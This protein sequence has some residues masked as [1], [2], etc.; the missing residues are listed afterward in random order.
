MCVV[1]ECVCVCVCVCV[2]IEWWLER[3]NVTHESSDCFECLGAW[4]INNWTEVSTSYGS[5]W[6]MGERNI[7]QNGL[8]YKLC[9][10][11]WTSVSKPHSSTLNIEFCLYGTSV[12]HSGWCGRRL[13]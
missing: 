10:H 3:S 6:Q 1:C 11:N 12:V 7:W 13:S 9:H 4:S 2:N 5:A 8:Y